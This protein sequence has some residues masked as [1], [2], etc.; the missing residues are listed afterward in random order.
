MQSV[1]RQFLGSTSQLEIESA[2][3][4]VTKCF[5]RIG[6]GDCAQLGGS[7]PSSCLDTDT[8]RGFPG[9]TADMFASD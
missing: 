5:Y 3:A 7:L 4:P 6:N 2:I 1:F 8:A 9:V